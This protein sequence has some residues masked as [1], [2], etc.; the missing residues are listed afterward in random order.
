MNACRREYSLTFPF[1]WLSSW[2][3][4]IF[5][6]FLWL[7]AYRCW[8]FL[9][10]SRLS[11]KK[12]NSFLKITFVFLRTENIWNIEKWY[13]KNISKNYIDEMYRKNISKRGVCPKWP[14]WCA[15]INISCQKKKQC[16]FSTVKIFTMDGGWMQSF[17]FFFSFILLWYIAH[18]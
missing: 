4:P 11:K 2:L 5:L 17:F 8:L 13:R 10:A 6:L 7:L 3:L 15:Q 9:A 14:F 16:L 18:V 1:S 12:K